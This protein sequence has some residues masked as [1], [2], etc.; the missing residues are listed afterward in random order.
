MPSTTDHRPTDDQT[1]TDDRDRDRVR[2][3]YD[4]VLR[5]VEQNTGGPGEPQRAGLRRPELHV[6]LVSHGPYD[7]EEVEQSIRAALAD[8]VRP[9]DLVE[10]HDE[11]GVPRLARRTVEGLRMVVAEQNMRDEPDVELQEWAAEQLEEVRDD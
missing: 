6:I 4:R 7:R 2:Q 1:P 9:P 5:T 10:W 8:E 3:R 11:E